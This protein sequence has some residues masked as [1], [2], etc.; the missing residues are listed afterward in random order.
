[1]KT[2]SIHELHE[3]TDLWVRE[4][5]RYGEILVTDSG[6]SVAKLVPLDESPAT[7]SFQDWQ[8]SPAY[9][10][11]MDRPVGG[12]DPPLKLTESPAWIETQV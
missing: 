10:A 7:T 1:M 6:K 12:P 8:P 9:A 4:A 11:I 5:A 2:I 3:E